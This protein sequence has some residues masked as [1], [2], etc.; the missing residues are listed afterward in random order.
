MRAAD[1][2]WMEMAVRVA[3]DDRCVLPIGSVEQHAYLSLCTDVILAGRVAEEAAAPTGVP[4]FPTLPYGMVPGFA[5]YPGTVSLRMSTYAALLEDLLEGLYRSGFRRI[6]VVN[7][8]G[9]N[10][11]V[12]TVFAE[13]LGRRTDARVKLHDWWRAPLTLKK[14]LATDPEASHASW[15]ENFPWTRLPG[16]PQPEGVKP[17]AALE[18]MAR[19]D[20]LTRREILG[21]GNF[22]GRYQRP[23]EEML[24]IW[25]V[26]V[27]ETRAA[28]ERDWD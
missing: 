5:A 20:P 14:V 25:E 6:L 7:G 4:V 24:A 10:T 26:A 11:P 13:W 16:R 27:A 18:R 22:H 28:I 15:M 12:G 9:G 1:M 23:D 8:H 2:N 17:R 19:V 3:Q 21:D